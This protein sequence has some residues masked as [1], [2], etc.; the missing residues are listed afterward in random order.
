MNY[1]F[2]SR[3]P[4]QET[5]VSLPSFRPSELADQISVEEEAHDLRL[6][7]NLRL[8]ANHLHASRVEDAIG[9]FII[10]LGIVHAFG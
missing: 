4:I 5:L 8:F 9:H 3:I 6:P 2:C 7:G 10:A 1:F